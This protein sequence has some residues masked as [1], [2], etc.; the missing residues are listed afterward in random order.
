M[1][2]A[3]QMNIDNETTDRVDPNGQ[4]HDRYGLDPK[5]APNTVNNFVNPHVM[6]ITQDSPSTE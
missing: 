3:P 6:A 5:L 2:S 1:A 4:R